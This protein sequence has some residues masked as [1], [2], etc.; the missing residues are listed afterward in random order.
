MSTAPDYVRAA[1]AELG[2]SE[3]PAG[4]NRTKFAAEASHANGYPWCATFL[5]AIARRTGLT[6]PN[7]SAYTPTMAQGFRNK[8]RWHSV[9]RYGDFVFYDFP[10]NSSR[11]QH[12]GVVEMV[13]PDG[14]IEAIEGNT[15]FGNN[16]NGGTVMRRIRSQASVVGY[17]R[18]LWTEAPAPVEPPPADSDFG[19]KVRMKPT[20]S[21][22]AA[23]HDVALL[24]GLL[25]A[26]A[27]DVVAYASGGY[28]K[29][30]GFVDGTFGSGTDGVLREW[31]RRTG[32]LAADGVCGP[33][34]WAWLVGV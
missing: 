3:T 17:G 29:V 20:L 18:P 2:Y 19:G 21:V 34:T 30:H 13:R 10:D 14:K 16:A 5:V 9:P 7:E 8:G 24:Q 4:S 32:A 1:A 6:L 28:E 27:K 22:G 31:Q 33:K 11:I 26:H 23:G 15:S 12:V 25:V